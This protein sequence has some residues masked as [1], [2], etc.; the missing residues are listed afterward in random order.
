MR[1]SLFILLFTL[2]ASCKNDSPR[3]ATIHTAF[4]DMQVVLFDHT[5]LHRDNFIK[6]VEEGFYDSLTFHRIIP[7]FMIQG[8]DPESKDAPADYNLGTG[9]PGY[10]IPAE[11]GVPHFSGML[12]A[13]RQ[14][15]AANPTRASSGSQFYIVDGGR[16]DE[17]DLNIAQ[18]MKKI[19]YTEAQRTRYLE[20]GGY[21]MLDNE[22]TVFGEVI[23][24]N[25]VISQIAQQPRGYADK[26]H[27]DIRM[28]ITMDN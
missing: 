18:K 25:I 28:T 23:S 15:D 9:G 27:K 5:P 13:A 6:L 26:P 4:G 22:Y 16:L 21:P 19:R 1:L 14:G 8:G 3:K 17:E 20:N 12:A 2:V 10:T 24:G 7:G 11:I